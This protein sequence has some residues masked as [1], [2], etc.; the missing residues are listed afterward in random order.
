MFVLKV[1]KPNLDPYHPRQWNADVECG[2]CGRGI[3]NRKTC[4]IAITKWVP[5]TPEDTHHFLKIA[6]YEGSTGPGY[7]PVAWGTFVGSHCAK[8][9][10][11]EYRMTWNK[12][13]KEWAKNDY[14]DT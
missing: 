7:D 12:C 5:G 2:I 4:K 14:C 10:P 11:K 8:K 3:P 9:L 6:E 13:M 1:E